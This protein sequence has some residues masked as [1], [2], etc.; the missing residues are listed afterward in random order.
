[1]LTWVKISEQYNTII[2]N[3]I[4]S[5]LITLLFILGGFLIAREWLLP[6][7]RECFLIARDYF[8]LVRE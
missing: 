8:L 1:M 6:L 3:Y 7:I 5:I 2:L 4:N